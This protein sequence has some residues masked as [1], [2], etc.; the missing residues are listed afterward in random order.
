MLSHF[1]VLHRGT[2]I[3]F[4]EKAVVICYP[5]KEVKIMLKKLSIA[6]MC[7]AILLS[8]GACSKEDARQNDG[9]PSQKENALANNASGLSKPTEEKQ[10][11]FQTEDVVRI[12]FYGYYG[13]GKGSDV[14]AE[15]L[16]EIITWLDS[17]EVD[18]DREFP[19]LIPPGTNTFHVE[20]EYT[21]GSIV[22]QGMDT[23]VVDG[24]TYY[25]SGD[26]SPKCYDEIISKISFNE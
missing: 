26:T 25:I 21:N 4:L 6:T 9:A 19:E 8:F 11:V 23:T 10:V 12:T 22:K 17:F 24:V 5:Y 1:C 13:G 7:I 15:Y 3:Y 16:S 18:T 2:N 14:P 20:I